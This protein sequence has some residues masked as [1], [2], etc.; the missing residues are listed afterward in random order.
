[1]RLL[2]RRNVLSYSYFNNKYTWIAVRE[3]ATY[4]MDLLN[5]TSKVREERERARELQKKFIGVAGKGGS[6][7]F[8]GAGEFGRGR[9]QL[10][11]CQCRYI[12]L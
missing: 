2:K 6:I 12:C 1:M 5:S 7:G 4:L 9:E 10:E 11:Q 8:S 3:K